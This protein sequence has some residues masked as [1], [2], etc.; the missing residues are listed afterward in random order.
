MLVLIA[1]PAMRVAVCILSFY[2]GGLGILY[3]QQEEI[4]CYGSLVP[5]KHMLIN[6]WKV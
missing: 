2:L 6:F 5:I 1:I 4:G 3:S